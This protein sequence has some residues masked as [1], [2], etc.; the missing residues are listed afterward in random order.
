MCI[1]ETRYDIPML[2]IFKPTAFTMRSTSVVSAYASIKAASFPSVKR[3]VLSAEMLIN[4]NTESIAIQHISATSSFKYSIVPSTVAQHIS[5]TE[6]RDKTTTSKPTT[7][8]YEEGIC[9]FYLKSR[10]FLRF[11]WPKRRSAFN[12][13]SPKIS[14]VILLS[15]FYTIPLMLAR[16]L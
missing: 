5:T 11:Y 6:G 1:F 2:Y 12:T 13:F 10:T 4:S 9:K 15:L 8:D 7:E 14:V 3:S 16:I